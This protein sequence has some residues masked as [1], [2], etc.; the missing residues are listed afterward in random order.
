M[1]NTIVT[2]W[3]GNTQVTAY[4]T[5]R[6]WNGE[7]WE[8]IVEDKGYLVFK[9]DLYEDFGEEEEPIDFWEDFVEYVLNNISYE[10]DIDFEDYEVQKNF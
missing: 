10:M 8:T 9:E 2:L 6:K 1:A 3:R 5:V 4:V 7:E